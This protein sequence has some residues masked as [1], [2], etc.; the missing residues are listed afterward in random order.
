MEE[1]E[2]EEEFDVKSILRSKLDKLAIQIGYAGKQR[3]LGV[4][5]IVVHSFTGEEDCSD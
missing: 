1:E 5:G 2:D 3:S 4:E